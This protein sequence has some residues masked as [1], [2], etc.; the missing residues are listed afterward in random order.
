METGII[1][2]RGYSPHTNNVHERN[3]IFRKEEQSIEGNEGII[4]GINPLGKDI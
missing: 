3:C 2:F 1:F 4:D